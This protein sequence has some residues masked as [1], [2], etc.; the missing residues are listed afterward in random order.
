MSIESECRSILSRALDADEA[1]DKELAIELYGKAVETILRIEDRERREKL[2]KFAKQ[3]LDRA[4][5]LKGIKYVPPADLKVPQGPTTS[6]PVRSG[7]TNAGR[8]IRN[9]NHGAFI[10]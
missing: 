7:Y 5:E 8:F 1:G 9:L 4:E 3:A 6:H 2:N 10:N